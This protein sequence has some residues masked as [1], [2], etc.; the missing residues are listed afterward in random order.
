MEVLCFKLHS[1]KFVNHCGILYH[2]SETSG[3]KDTTEVL[4]S[5]SFFLFPD[6]VCL[7]LVYVA[8][9]VITYNKCVEI[10]KYSVATISY[11]LIL[12]KLILLNIIFSVS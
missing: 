1:Y 9:Y 6:T 8:K 12:F 10:L 3:H 4:N 11:T 5:S 2:E 7:V